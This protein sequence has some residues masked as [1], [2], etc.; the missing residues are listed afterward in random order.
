MLEAKQDRD[1]VVEYNHFTGP[2]GNVLQ[3][4][5]YYTKG[6]GASISIIPVELKHEAGFTSVSFAMFDPR[7]FRARVLAYPRGN[8]KRLARLAAAVNAR[9]DEVLAA[10]A[11]PTR[12]ALV[13]LL[14]T[15]AQEAK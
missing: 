10:Y 8:P 2:E 5:L 9:F 13:D 1:G 12:S 6:K 4:S 14:G 15:I 11:Q 7:A 3:L